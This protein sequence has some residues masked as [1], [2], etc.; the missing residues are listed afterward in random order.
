M[1]WLWYPEGQESAIAAVRRVTVTKVDDSGTQQL[2]NLR[3]LAGEAP[4]DIVHLSR[5]GFGS[6]PVLGSEGVGISLGGRSDRLMV[7]GLE[8]KDHRRKNLPAGTSVVYDNQGNIVFLKGANGI[9]VSAQQG[10]VSVKAGAGQKVFLG[11]TGDDG[12]YDFVLTASG[13]SPFVKA[14][15]S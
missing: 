15:I 12:S 10:K 3:G 4:E 14:R 13:P 5:F 7:L 2:V 8:H 11:G 6:N 9:E 1:P